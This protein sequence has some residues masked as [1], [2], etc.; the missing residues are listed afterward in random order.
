MEVADPVGIALPVLE[1]PRKLPTGV[2]WRTA[3]HAAI[4]RERGQKRRMAETL[5][6]VAA[7]AKTIQDAYNESLPLRHGDFIDL[8]GSNAPSSW[9]HRTALHSYSP[10]SLSTSQHLLSLGGANWITML[11]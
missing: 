2:A 8:D 6:G 10:P 3:A 5:D 1:P 7:S 9:R 4:M 11:P